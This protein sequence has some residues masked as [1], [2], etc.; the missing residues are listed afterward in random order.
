MPS[1]SS[2]PIACTP[3]SV[4]TEKVEGITVQSPSVS[5]TAIHS[6]V[7]SSVATRESAFSSIPSEALHLPPASSDSNSILHLIDD[8]FQ[9]SATANRGEDAALEK[10]YRRLAK[11]SAQHPPDTPCTECEAIETDIKLDAAKQHS[12]SA[13]MTL[14]IDRVE[15]NNLNKSVK[16]SMVQM[17]S[18]VVDT[19]AWLT[20]HVLDIDK[21]SQ[22]KLTP[23]TTCSTGVSDTINTASNSIKS[24]LDKASFIVLS[25]EN[26]NSS[27][28]KPFD[29][30][31]N[32]CCFCNPMLHHHKKHTTDDQCSA[33]KCNFC[34]SSRQQTAQVTP[35]PSHPKT[36]TPSNDSNATGRLSSAATEHIFESKCRS[37]HSHIRRQSKDSA[38][39]NTICTKK[40][41]R[42]TRKTTQPI[43][44]EPLLGHD[45]NANDTSKMGGRAD[46]LHDLNG[47]KATASK[48]SSV[49]KLPP[50]SSHECW[51]SNSNDT[52]TSSPSSSS[53]ESGSKAQRRR[54]SKSVPN[55]PKA[56]RWPNVEAKS[57]NVKTKSRSNSRYQEFYNDTDRT[58]ATSQS[59]NKSKPAGK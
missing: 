22:F 46:E 44:S 34:L 20:P 42:T 17:S 21:M 32:D 39:I 30:P 37:S 25:D 43:G 49:P 28:R 18:S 40:L 36:T 6:T 48:K 52:M 2:Q 27:T 50:P 8:T 55:L 57:G 4:D 31:C 38:T 58:V 7:A 13:S 3:L 54:N 16:P 23:I 9:T 45:S 15:E 47:N 56:D 11:C 51:Q 1:S 29:R 12:T 10:P 19:N 35:M 5:S 24:V 41:N 26:D 14:P 59:T 33:K 53:N